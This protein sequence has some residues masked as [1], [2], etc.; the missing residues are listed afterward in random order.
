MTTTTPCNSRFIFSQTPT[1]EPLNLDRLT[2]L[3][4]VL[5]KT[6]RSEVET[7]NRTLAG[8][9]VLELGCGHG[10]PI[11]FS[12]LQGASAV[13]FQDFSSEV[14]KCLRILNIVANLPVKSQSQDTDADVWFFAGD[15][16][17]VRAEE[18]IKSIF[19]STEIVVKGRIKS[20]D[21][22]E[23]VGGEERRPNWCELNVQV[24]IKRDEHLVR[25]YGLFVT[26]SDAI[27]ATVAWPC[28]F[29]SVVREDDARR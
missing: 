8:K 20:L 23:I 14:I 18:Y 17:E 6:L 11:I 12:C 22:N 4:E 21:P 28:P 19:I 27:G 9:N 5:V 24:S 1:L 3:K 25:R 29:V 13:H 16:S 15:C 2:L 26:I 7:N 10:L